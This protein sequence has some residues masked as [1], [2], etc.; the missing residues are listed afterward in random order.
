LPSDGSCETLVEEL[1]RLRGPTERQPFEQL[2]K[3]DLLDLFPCVRDWYDRM[4]SRS[5]YQSAIAS[6]VNPKY[7]PS[8]E[9][10][11]NEA[12]PK[13]AAILGFA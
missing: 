2:R 1:V 4:R 5:T 7:L 6:Q 3:G 8:M 12:W 9:E 13:V 10:K 11:G